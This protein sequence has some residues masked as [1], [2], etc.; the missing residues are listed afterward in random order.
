MQR[1]EVWFVDH[2]VESERVGLIVVGHSMSLHISA[3]A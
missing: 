1:Q 3:T 2:L